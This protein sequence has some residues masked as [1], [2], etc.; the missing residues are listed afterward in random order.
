MSRRTIL[1]WSLRGRCVLVQAIMS[2]PS[3]FFFFPQKKMGEG[4]Y[5]SHVWEQ[6]KH[7]TAN[8]RAGLLLL[9]LE[10]GDEGHGGDLHNLETNSWNITL[11]LTLT[12]E[13]GEED[14]ILWTTTKTKAKGKRL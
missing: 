14:L 7:T 1:K 11:S 12:T 4:G 6:T 8:L 5:F 3:Q 9:A 13:T 10:E 2:P